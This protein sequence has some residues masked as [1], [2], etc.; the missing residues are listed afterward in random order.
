[1]RILNRARIIIDSLKFFD[2]EDAAKATFRYGYTIINKGNTTARV[3]EVL[4]EVDVFDSLPETPPYQGTPIARQY[5]VGP[6]H[7][8]TVTIRDIKKSEIDM[9]KIVKLYA[10]GFIRYRDEFGRD[11]ITRYARLYPGPIPNTEAFVV[12]KAGYSDAT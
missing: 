5:S 12:D 8:M 1:M 2:V 4:N 6:N 3:F 11:W 10:L 7:T 9:T